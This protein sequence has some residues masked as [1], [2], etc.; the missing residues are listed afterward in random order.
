[1]LIV[2]IILVIVIICLV[3]LAFRFFFPVIQV[4]GD[5]M[6][7]TYKDGE[8]LLSRRVF[9]RKKVQKGDVIVYLMHENGER[10]VIKR[11]ADIKMV[12]N[13]LSF[14]CLGDNPKESYDS[15]YYGYIPSAWLVC[16]P[17]N[18]RRCLK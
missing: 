15:R 16:K 10:N 6:F 8:V 9:S 13:N 5:S 4:C 12:E 7:P 17:F 1:M 2:K 18:Q 3:Y 11:V 14:Y